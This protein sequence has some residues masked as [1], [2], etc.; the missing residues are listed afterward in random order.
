MLKKKYYLILVIS[1]LLLCGCSKNIEKKDKEHSA[2]KENQ[3]IVNETLFSIFNPYAPDSKYGYINKKGEVIVEEQYDLAGEFKEGLAPV[4]KGGKT[5]YIDASGR[6]VFELDKKYTGYAFSEGMAPVYDG[7]NNKYGYIDING[8]V[9]IDSSYDHAFG[10]S[11]D[12]APV[13]IDGNYGYIDKKG[14]MVINPAF[15]FAEGFSE[16]LAAVTVNKNGEEQGGYI[17]TKGKFVIEP[18]YEMVF[19]FSEGLAC[20]KSNGKFGYI[21]KEGKFAIEPEYEYA[22]SFSEGLAGV[23]VEGKFGYIDKDGNFAIEPVF[24]DGLEFS[25]GLSLVKINDEDLGWGYINKEGKVVIEPGFEHQKAAHYVTSG[26]FSNGLAKVKGDGLDWGYINKDGEYVWSTKENSG[27]VNRTFE[28]K[29]LEYKNYISSLSKKDYNSVS[30]AF[31]K[32]KELASEDKLENDA[33]FKSFYRL[34]Q[35]V[36]YEIFDT[37]SSG[38]YIEEEDLKRNGFVSLSFEEGKYIFSHPDYLKDNF[39]QYVSEE[40]KEFILL[41]SKDKNIRGGF[42][43]TDALLSIGRDELCDLIINWENYLKKYSNVDWIGEMVN[44]DINFYIY[45]YTSIDLMSFSD[46]RGETDRA[47]DILQSY[48]RFLDN[49]P[50]SRYY[51]L[52]KEYYRVLKRNGVKSTEETREI[53]TKF[54]IISNDESDEGEKTG[55]RDEESLRAVENFISALKNKN[56]SEIKDNISSSGIIVIRNFSSGFGNRGKDVRNKYLFAEIPDNFQFEVADETPIDLCYLFQKAAEYGLDEI[57]VLNLDEFSFFK[58]SD[59]FDLQEI[60]TYNLIDKC[61]MLPNSLDGTPQIFVIGS[62]KIV[63]AETYSE[64]DGTW[65]IFENEGGKYYLKIVLNI[66]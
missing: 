38:G 6:E 35:E 65:A 42:L 56:V 59:V 22:L 27:D 29:T 41:D 14:N 19:S 54:N 49:Y 33:M 12:L 47:E 26:K 57:P 16:G 28:N 3:T 51:Q 15:V 53:L 23:F 10:F 66:R 8:K 4:R 55:T 62:K 64:F 52:I 37:F 48:E 31:E 36:N 44:K 20:V 61:S 11:E 13:I 30:K 40:I 50:N 1:V 43:V 45:L 24:Y 34:Y 7:E 21:D 18:E 5:I 58:D 63:L 60:S 9:V 17:N 32:F 2:A 39:T 25:E 46:M